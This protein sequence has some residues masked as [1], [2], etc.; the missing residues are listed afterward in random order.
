MPGMEPRVLD[1]RPVDGL[2]AYERAGGGKAQAIATEVGPVEL[3]Q[4]I[5]DSGLRGRGGAG[6]P[7]GLKWQTVAE[8]TSS[9]VPDDGG[10]ERRRR[11][12]GLVQGPG[13]PAAQPVPRARGRADRRPGGRRRPAGRRRSRRRSPP[14]RRACRSRHRRGEGGGL[15]RRGRRARWSRARA[16]TSSA[17]RPRCSR[18]STGGAPFPRIAPAVAPW[19]CD[20]VG[21]PTRCEPAGD[22]E[23][24]SAGDE[25]A[26]PP[27]LVNNVET[28][29]NVPGIVAERRRLVP[30][31]RHRGVAGTIV[32]TVIGRT[33][34]RDGVG[35]GRRW[36]RRSR[37][38][39]RDRWRGP[40]AADEIVAVLSGVA[41]PLLPGRPARHAA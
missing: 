15:V 31:G 34:A 24:A 28:L 10:G 4:L 9:Q 37:G 27:T 25:T 7:T 19:V 41:N 36:A 12:A 16:S 23:M 3:I 38:D 29:A 39:R 20:F 11:R 40:P 6:F 26:A 8:N 30:G 14:R 2:D 22:V 18:W 32:C 33:P 13:D 1:S 17:R 35:R 5:T 21:R